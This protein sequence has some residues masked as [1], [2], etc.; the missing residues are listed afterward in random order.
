[1]SKIIVP[2]LLFIISVGL[3]FTYLKPAYNVYLAFK[4]QEKRLDTAIGDSKELLK[5]YDDLYGEYSLI[6]ELQKEKLNKILPNA[7]DMVHLVL[8]L[9]NLATNHSLSIKSFEIPDLE[10]DKVSPSTNRRNN[11]NK[12]NNANKDEDDHV[13]KAVLGVEVAGEY[14]DFKAFL[15]D[16]ERS[17]SL[18]DVVKLDIETSDMTKPGVEDKIVY[19]LGLQVYWL[20]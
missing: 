7:V 6:T 1:M 10:S 13:A 19:S 18:M 16:I 12:N 4:E 2:I 11:R 20:K 17:L 8:D 3:Y 9:D 15:Y 5:K 14:R